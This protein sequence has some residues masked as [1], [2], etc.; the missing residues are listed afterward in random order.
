MA[1]DSKDKVFSTIKQNAAEILF[2]LFGTF[3]Q[4]EQ[5]YSRLAVV[6]SVDETA[7]TASVSLVDGENIEDVRIQQVSSE[8]G[9]FVKPAIESVVIVSFYFNDRPR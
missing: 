2:E 7:Q 4:G 6:K 9:L 1:K 8:F 3:M 5:Y